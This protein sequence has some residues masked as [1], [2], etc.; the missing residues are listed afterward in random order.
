M[1]REA[2]IPGGAPFYNSFPFAKPLSVVNST[3]V[4]GGEQTNGISFVKST[5]KI[6]YE[7]IV[8]VLTDRGRC[9]KSA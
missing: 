1:T 8:I 9:A 7:F 4:G 5:L 6:D 3:V 2:Y